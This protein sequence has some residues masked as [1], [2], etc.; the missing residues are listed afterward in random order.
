MNITVGFEGK[1]DDS[2]LWRVELQGAEDEK[3]E[4]FGTDRA[5]ALQDLRVSVNR[6]VEAAIKRLGPE[7]EMCSRC[8]EVMAP[9]MA[10]GYRYWLCALGHTEPRDS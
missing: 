6:E 9:V 8:D 4:G 10:R 1:P 2:V 7:P 3:L 5:M